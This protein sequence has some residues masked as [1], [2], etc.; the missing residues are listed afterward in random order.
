[1]TRALF[2]LNTRC[3]MA[4]F[5][6]DIEDVHLNGRFPVCLLKGNLAT[7]REVTPNYCLNCLHY[8]PCWTVRIYYLHHLSLKKLDNFF[9]LFH[10]P[11]PSSQCLLFFMPAFLW[12]VIHFFTLCSQVL[13][14]SYYYEAWM[15]TTTTITTPP[16]SNNIVI[17]INPLHHLF[18]SATL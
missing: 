18:T 5:F 2:N 3:Q 10:P 12:F 14:E 1:M 9:Y 15:F 8:N 16:Q 7:W 11:L 4:F 13:Y 6:S 17:Q